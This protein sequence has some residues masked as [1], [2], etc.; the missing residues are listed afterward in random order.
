MSKMEFRQLKYFVTIADAGSITKAAKTLNISQP[1]LSRQ[2]KILEAE[3]GFKLFKRVNNKGIALTEQGVF[4]LEKAREL[5]YK[6]DNIIMQAR[7]M[8]EKVNKKLSIGTTI[9]S[10]QL[11]FK[12]I[13]NYQCLITDN[14][15]FNIWEEDSLSLLHLLNDRKI[16][17]AYIHE[18]ESFSEIMY[19]PIIEDYCV[20][21]AP[22]NNESHLG[23]TISI[24]EIAELPLI[25]LDSNNGTGLYKQI[26]DTLKT[27]QL[28][29]EILCEC[30]DSS[31]LS[32]LL[33][34]GFG[35]TILPSSLIT[36][37]IR[38]KYTVLP[39]QNNPWKLEIKLAWKKD[40]YQPT[41]L[42]KYIDMILE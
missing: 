27:Y 36:D 24:N 15:N 21:V 31:V 32:Q 19:V 5:L 34:R 30:H 16:D 11:M 13:E 22:I 42:S 10:S 8:D 2:L 1:P 14:I 20:Y 9:Y 12:D 6:T 38:K 40:N 39:I 25:L 4:F 41:H 17:I 3:L 33:A 18:T 37:E 29:P 35:G 23:K 28:N 7:E 26:V